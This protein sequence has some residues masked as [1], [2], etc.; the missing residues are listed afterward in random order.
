MLSVTVAS[1][2]SGPTPYATLK[3]ACQ[4]IVLDFNSPPEGSVL[5]DSRTTETDRGSVSPP[6]ALNV[7]HVIRNWYE[8]LTRQF[9]TLAIIQELKFP[10]KLPAEP[11]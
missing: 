10:W 2:R 9:P 8:T 6:G 7:E 11:T 3:A 5:F 1:R 4:R